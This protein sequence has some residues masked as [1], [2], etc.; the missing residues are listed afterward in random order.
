M[1]YDEVNYPYWIRSD[2]VKML[3]DYVM[4]AADFSYEPRGTITSTSLGT[5]IVVDTGLGGWGWHDICVSGW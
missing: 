2:G 3:G 4:C 5:A 1:G